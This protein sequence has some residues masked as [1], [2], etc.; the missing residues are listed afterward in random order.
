MNLSLNWLKDFVDIPKKM[1]P[2]ELGLKLTMHTVEIDSV[3]KQVDKY[4]NIVVGKILEVS[5]HPDAD[6]LQ[7]AKVDINKQVLDIVCGASNIAAGQF[8]PVALVG[9][10]LPNGAEIKEAEIRGQKSYG[11]LCAE[12]ELVLGEDHSG[13]LILD[14]KSRIGQDF[15]EYLKINDVIFEVDN[16]SITNRPD[17][18]GHYGMA[19][20]IAAFLKIRTT[21]K[22]EQISKAKI[23][24]DLKEIKL[25]VEVKD[26]KLC[27]RYM[28]IVMDGIKVEVSPKWLQE[29][30]ISVGVRP[31][32]NIVDITNYV[33]LEIGQP[34]HAFDKNLVDEI[35]VRPAKEKEEIE[36]LD[37]ERRELD[38]SDLVIA[39]SKK[40]IAIAGVMGGANSE[41]NNDTATIIL[42]SANFDFISIRKTSQKLGLRTEASMR[43]EKSLDPNLCE[44]AL[45]RAVSL[46]KEICPKSKVVSEIAD[47]NK[48]SINQGPIELNLDWL[49]GFIGNDIGEGE[50]VSILKR[51]GFDVKNKNNSL[52]VTVP[53]WRATKDISIKEDLAEEIARIY[54]YDNLKLFMPKIEMKK[55]GVSVETELI[56]EI[57]QVLS[58][59][60]AMSEVYNYSFVGEDLLR[61]LN[62]DFSR[63]IH[64]ANPIS[65]QHTMLRQNLA[66]NLFSNVRVNQSRYEMFK[67]FE[68]GSVFLNI[69]G[70]K[71]KDAESG[72]KLPYQEKRLGILVAGEIKD[73]VF[74]EAK[75]I[76][77]YLFDSL[78]LD[79]RFDIAGVEAA[80]VW[81]DKN[82][83]AKIKAGQKLVGFVSV[84]DKKIGTS[85]GIKKECAIAEISLKELLEVVGGA[86]EKKYKETDKYPSAVRDLAFV[87]NK[88]ILYNDIKEEIEKY[89]EYI[90]EI[91]L[92]DTYEGDKVGE[93]KKNLAFHIVYQAGRTMTADEVDKLQQGLIKRMEE[94]FEAKVRNF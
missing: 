65:A 88:K 32:N 27:P 36:T 86:K 84:L 94:K 64:L 13:I 78:G 77:E 37:G 2:E 17:L 81:S 19:R 62:I 74:N 89:H 38:E 22:F 26:F 35:I 79:V 57:K 72:E 85:L 16:K 23:K 11:M 29:R 90:K 25:G 53:T 87:V 61:K 34:M 70:E 91:E 42:E 83:T 39:D 93:G 46:I 15:S 14:N 67:I 20:D 4:K 18:W 28:G 69:D 12:D 44:L 51:L 59:G 21:K 47:E 66:P 54:G 40:A 24:I 41:I 10:V 68:I 43:F 73:N 60:V 76:A 58:G 52:L 49:N 50:I 63:H 56:D 55:P 7:L 3:Q 45:A 5:K 8:V 71:N 33:M 6:K 30:L 48:F 1:T 31:I 9:A 80:P 92:F 82:R 75:G